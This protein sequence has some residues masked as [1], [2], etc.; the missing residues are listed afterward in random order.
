MR[1]ALAVVALLVLAAAIGAGAYF[2]GRG[3]I[4]QGAVAGRAYA[5]GAKN[6]RVQGHIAG[7][8]EAQSDSAKTERATSADFEQRA[9]RAQGDAF[10]AGWNAVFAEF[11]SWAPGGYYIVGIEDGTQGAHYDLHTRL[12]MRAN[13]TY[14]LCADGSGICGRP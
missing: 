10:T 6:G 5:E 3:S 8:A 12:E 7:Y 14:A 2:I 4:D 11:G 9:R 1:R 13:Q